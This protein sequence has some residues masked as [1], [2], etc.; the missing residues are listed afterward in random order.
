MKTAIAAVLLLVCSFYSIRANAQSERFA[1]GRLG[2]IKIYRQKG[3]PTHVILFVS[4][5][6]GWTKEVSEV[7]EK[8]SSPDVIVGGV[9]LKLYVAN[10][11]RGHDPCTYPSAEFEHLS[12]EIQKKYNFTKY[13]Q[14]VLLG[15]LEGATLVYAATAA[16]PPNTYA[17]AIS[18][19]FCP[20]MHMPQPLCRG[21]ELRYKTVEKGLFSF[22]PAK[23]LK[24]SWTVL[25]GTQDK[26]CDSEGMKAYVADVPNAKF[27]PLQGLGHNALA[28]PKSFA[29]LKL[30][31]DGLIPKPQPAPVAQ[32]K[33]PPKPS[34]KPADLPL[35]EV[36]ATGTPTDALA[37]IL[38][39]D[40]GWASLDREVGDYMAT[41][42]I[43]V[44]GFD[45][46]QY[47]WNKRSPEEAAK[48][49]ARAMQYYLS[50]WHKQN[51]I[52]IGYSFGADILPFLANRLPPDL[53][54]RVKLIGLLG[55]SQ[56]ANFEFHVTEW[57]GSS[58]GSDGRPVLPE[59]KKL[60]GPKTLCFY[61]QKEDDSLCPLLDATQATN[62]VFGGGHHFGGDYK[63]IAEKIVS[64]LK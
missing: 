64:Q 8:L 3:T 15:Y 9:D 1:F 59:M 25:H 53:L 14:P 20:H 24:T 33:A 49:L 32:Q 34:E 23:D 40:G 7:A 46:L 43:P 38:T 61:G 16:G 31:V 50:A 44:V 47:F 13:N 41:Q 2:E 10:L 57:L 18:I 39:G 19:G 42:G 17:G 35:V 11:Q 21:E 56:T 51:V 52:L 30:V 48:D 63:A 26:V 58:Y 27:I 12:Q 36:P 22:L 5:A 55:P 37:V 6:E 60:K 29:P 45:C 62:I 28:S 4:G 54:A